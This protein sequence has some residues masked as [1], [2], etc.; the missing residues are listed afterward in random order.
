MSRF[1][2]EH[3]RSALTWILAGFALTLV[4]SLPLAVHASTGHACHEPRGATWATEGLNAVQCATVQPGHSVNVGTRTLNSA[5]SDV[6]VWGR[7]NVHGSQR[8]LRQ[9]L[10]RLSPAE[11]SQWDFEGYLRGYVAGWDTCNGDVY[12]YGDHAL[13]VYWWADEPVNGGT[14]VPPTPQPDA[15]PQGREVHH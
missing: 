10:D 5:P 8:H 11:C 2:R 1:K 9:S 14:R 4:L 12:N 7:A 15:Q 13:V 6:D 3:R